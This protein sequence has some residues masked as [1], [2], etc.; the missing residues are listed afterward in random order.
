M[1]PD[2][3]GGRRQW[4]TNIMRLAGVSRD[5]SGCRWIGGDLASMD[6]DQAVAELQSTVKTNGRR[7][8]PRGPVGKLASE[9]VETGR[10]GVCGSCEVRLKSAVDDGEA[11][12]GYGKRAAQ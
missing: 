11:E 5:G 9:R 1:R 12:A 3:E 10:Q 7:L 4:T 8:C 2:E 6:Q